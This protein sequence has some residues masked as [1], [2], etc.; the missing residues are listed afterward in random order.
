MNQPLFIYGTLR[1][2]QVQLTV[3]GRL[4]EGSPDQ[5]AGYKISGI[6]LDGVPYP[7]IIPAEESTVNGEVI[8]ITGAELEKIDIYEGEAYQR[9]T[10][11]L[12]SGRQAWVYKAGD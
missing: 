10:V 9:V 4:V 8:E 1:E 5:L 2:P 7:L 3:I 6:I 12:L 11:T